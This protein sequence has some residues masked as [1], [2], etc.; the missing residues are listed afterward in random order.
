MNARLAQYCK[1]PFRLLTVFLLPAALVAACAT[2]YYGGENGVYYQQHYRA[3]S[4]PRPAVIH[5]SP[6]VYPYW[7]LDY[8]Y[9]SR[10]YHPYSVFVPRFDP[11]YYP[12]PGW[13]YGYRPGRYYTAG[14]HHY[15]YPWYRYRDFYGDYRPGPDV[16]SPPAELTERSQ[17]RA[18]SRTAD[19]NQRLRAAHTPPRLDRQL[20][21]GT[22][23]ALP[24]TSRAAAV[25]RSAAWQRSGLSPRSAP[26]TNSRRAD[27]GEDNRRRAGSR[28]ARNATR[29]RP[30]AGTPPASSRQRS[31]SSRRTG[32]TGSR[33]TPANRQRQR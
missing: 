16:F 31:P 21:P 29:Q 32:T 28:P 30:A 14:D 33:R 11:W 26:V 15:R 25:R 27:R 7:S 12:Y 23:P 10:Y 3:R 5:A 8:F 24:A 19:I 18:I 20:V 9:F 6:F 4:A 13:Y 2:P 22:A 17:A 1:T